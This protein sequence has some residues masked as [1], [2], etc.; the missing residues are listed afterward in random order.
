MTPH[1]FRLRRAD[2][3]QKVVRNQVKLGAK[4]SVAILARHRRQKFL[5]PE[6]ARK[7][8]EINKRWILCLRKRLHI[9][10]LYSFVD[11]GDATEIFVKFLDGPRKFPKPWYGPR[12]KFLILGVVVRDFIMLPEE[13]DA[14]VTESILRIRSLITNIAVHICDFYKFYFWHRVIFQ[15]FFQVMNPRVTNLFDVNHVIPI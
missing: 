3:F 11:S 5:T 1:F 13:W 9:S 4:L 7:W 2:I 14:L 12:D 10:C 6:I 15:N 8:E